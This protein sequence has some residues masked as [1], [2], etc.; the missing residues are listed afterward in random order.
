MMTYT[1]D[2]STASSNIGHHHGPRAWEKLVGNG[3]W[4]AG[5]TCSLQAYEGHPIK[6]NLITQAKGTVGSM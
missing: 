2:A 3:W 1:V 6:Q 4:E 5:Y